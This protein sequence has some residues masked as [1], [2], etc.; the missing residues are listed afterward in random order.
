[1]A[2]SWRR[3]CESRHSSGPSGEFGASPNGDM[4]LDTGTSDFQKLVWCQF[5][6]C[7]LVPCRTWFRKD[8]AL[9]CSYQA[10]TGARLKHNLLLLFIQRSATQKAYQCTSVFIITTA[11]TV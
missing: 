7:P 9:F 11:E 5:K 4:H 1:M 8:C 6:C 10:L 2:Q 3:A